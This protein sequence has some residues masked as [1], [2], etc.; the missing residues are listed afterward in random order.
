MNVQPDTALNIYTVF[1]CKINSYLDQITTIDLVANEIKV[2]QYTN[3][4]V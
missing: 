2:I 3:D 1:L 4:V